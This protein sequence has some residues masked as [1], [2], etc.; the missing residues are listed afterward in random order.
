VILLQK[1]AINR[2]TGVRGHTHTQTLTHKRKKEKGKRKLLIITTESK[3][4]M[5]VTALL[6]RAIDVQKTYSS[7]NAALF[8]YRLLI[9]KVGPLIFIRA[10]NFWIIIYFLNSF[11]IYAYILYYNFAIFSVLSALIPI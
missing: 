5:E 4:A 3:P 1:Q 11:S 7:P 9:E 2:H 6:H 10:F 8:L